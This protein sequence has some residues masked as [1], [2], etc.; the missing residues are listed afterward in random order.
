[1]RAIKDLNA[2]SLVL[3]TLILIP[4]HRFWGFPK[5]ENSSL[6]FCA[7]DL[8]HKKT[9]IAPRRQER[10][11]NSF[12]FEL[13]DLCA[14]ARDTVF[15]ISFSSKISNIFGWILDPLTPDPFYRRTQLGEFLLDTFV[16]PIQVINPR[17]LGGAVGHQSRE[18]QRHAGPQIRR[19]HRRA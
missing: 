18:N 1:M 9:L 10:K 5:C 13:G 17:N 3:T 12:Y 15:P 16:T 2:G 4:T 19:H 7:G 11:E 8:D 6:T 14:F